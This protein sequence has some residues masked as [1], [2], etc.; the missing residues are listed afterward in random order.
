ME[1]EEGGFVKTANGSGM[2]LVG[3]VA[4]VLFFFFCRFSLLLV[5]Y[6]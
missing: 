2:R 3:E 4:E 5:V 1:G 6:L